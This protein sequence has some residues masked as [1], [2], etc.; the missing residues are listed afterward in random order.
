[1][2]TN[3]L[4]YL[5]T[6]CTHSSCQ[7]HSLLV[8]A[9]KQ[10]S[11]WANS[12]WLRYF[13]YLANLTSHCKLVWQRCWQDNRY[14]QYVTLQTSESRYITQSQ[15][16]ISSLAFL[17]ESLF[18]YLLVHLQFWKRSQEKHSPEMKTELKYFRNPRKLQKKLR[19]GLKENGNV[20]PSMND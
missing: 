17:L 11:H 15:S 4:L 10:I 7:P 5:N 19:L 13:D 18:I 3:T 20:S 2:F 12:F 8:A 1:M 9:W 6:D 16:R 14:R